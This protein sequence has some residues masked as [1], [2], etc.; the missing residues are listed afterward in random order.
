MKRREFLKY[1]TATA[2]TS[3]F[4]YRRALAEAPPIKVGVVGAK[5]GPLAP[6]GSDALS[7]LSIMGA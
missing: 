7:T 4:S 5:T 1:S 2:I 6:G 3:S